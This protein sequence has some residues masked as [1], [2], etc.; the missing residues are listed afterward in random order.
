MSDL[1]CDLNKCPTPM[2]CA[3]NRECPVR[4]HPSKNQQEGK[5]R[6]KP[7]Q[8]GLE[9]LEALDIDN[10]LRVLT[11]YAV[12]MKERVKHLECHTQADQVVISRECADILMNT[13]WQSNPWSAI[14]DETKNA[15]YEL[16]E[17]MEKAK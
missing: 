17:A 9:H 11:E 16:N 3:G 12:L 4:E 1:M 10:R 2:A 15:L 13:G 14:R 5:E 8:Y 6:A 7:E